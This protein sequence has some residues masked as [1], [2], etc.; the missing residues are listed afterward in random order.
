MN[1]NNRALLFTFP[2]LLFA[3]YHVDSRGLILFIGELY[4]AWEVLAVHMSRPTLVSI[5]VA[6]A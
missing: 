2:L 3:C 4:Y 6:S 1:K 5:L